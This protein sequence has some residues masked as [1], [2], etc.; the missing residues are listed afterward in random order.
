MPTTDLLRSSL[1]DEARALE[2]WA[3]SRGTTGP[4]VVAARA[5]GVVALVGCG[6]LGAVVVDVLASAGV[7]TVVLDDARQVRQADVGVGGLREHHVGRRRDD[8]V[9]DAAR[10]SHRAL[11]VGRR[12]ALSPDVVVLVVEDGGEV[13]RTAR[14]MAEGVAHLVVTVAAWGA[15]VGPFVLPGLTACMRCVELQ[16]PS[17]GRAGRGADGQ[18]GRGAGRD[19]GADIPGQVAGGT[20]HVPGG[21]GLPLLVPQPS[22]VAALAGA[23]VAAEVLAYLDGRRPATAGASIEVEALDAMPRLRGWSVHPRCG[24]TGM[25]AVAPGC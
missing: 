12:D 9:G 4:S 8:A 18:A 1:C 16:D 6:R 10:L 14:L 24:C 5:T 21:T 2:P 23:V 19:V 15:A 20:A 3:R 7:E 13:L 17:D 22:V 25:G 11:R